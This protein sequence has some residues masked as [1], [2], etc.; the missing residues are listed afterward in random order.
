[1]WLLPLVVFSEKGEAGGLAP[2]CNIQEGGTPGRDQLMMFSFR[3]YA[4]W[5]LCE[6]LLLEI[7]A[8]LF[9]ETYT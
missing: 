3:L 4:N 1:M 2:P 5:C 8:G 9:H 6:I 7:L